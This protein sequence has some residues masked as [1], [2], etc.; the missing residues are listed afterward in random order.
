MIRYTFRSRL[1]QRSLYICRTYKFLTSYLSHCA[2]W[3]LCV[4]SLERA[5][6]T[7]RY[8]WNQHVFSRKHSYYTLLLIY[9]SLFCLNSHYL[10]FFGT[11]IDKHDERTMNETEKKLSIMCSSNFVR[12]TRESYEYFLVYYFSWMD[13]FINSL[14]PFLIILFANS[15]VMYSVCKS[16]TGMKQLGMRQTRLPRDT[17]LAYILFVSTFL[18][19]LLTFP[20]RVFAVIEPYLKYE[21][22]YL[23]LL[24][25]IMRFLL[26]LDHGCGFYLYTFT[27]ELFRREMRKFLS[28]CLLRIC[29]RKYFHS[30]HAESRH[31][32]DLSYSNGLAGSCA[33]QCQTQHAHVHLKDSISSSN[34]IGI[35]GT[36]MK[37]SALSFQT[38]RTAHITSYQQCA[39]QKALL[40]NTLSSSSTRSRCLLSA[41]NENPSR[42]SERHGLVKRHSSSCLVTQHQSLIV[43]STSEYRQV[44]VNLDHRSAL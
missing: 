8:I 12:K 22:K 18:F 36:T 2:I 27:G 23:I 26:Y 43:P 13:F 19:L 16:H 3:I 40:T 35:T 39:Y 1:L 28:D 37:L 7:K 14:I 5:A 17:Q 34:D 11:K 15:S 33:I 29:C 25:G 9:V 32:S 44:P 31:F 4:I 30:N 6:V 20:L 21:R 41:T 10:L 42:S 38:I 24:D